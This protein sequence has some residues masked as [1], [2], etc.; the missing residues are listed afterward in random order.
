MAK[1]FNALRQFLAGLSASA[2]P[3]D[4]ISAMSPREFADLPVY[5]PR[6]DP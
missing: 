5:H 1:I 3:A 2:A 4:P 6:L